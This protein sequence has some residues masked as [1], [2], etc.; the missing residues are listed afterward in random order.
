M[1]AVPSKLRVLCPLSIFAP[2]GKTER[3]PNDIDAEHWVG[4]VKLC[5]HII[6][7]MTLDDLGGQGRLNI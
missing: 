2:V 7:A 6:I 4:L 5:Q 1:F 3:Y